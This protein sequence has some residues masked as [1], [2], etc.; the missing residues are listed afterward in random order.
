LL[1]S[2][3]LRCIADVPTGVF[4]SSGIDS[5]TITALLQA[6]TS[7][8]VR[9]F[10]IGFSEQAYDE[11]ND[12]S[13][14]AR[15]LGTDHLAITVTP[16]DAQAMIPKIP[17]IF[18]EPFSDSSL[19]PTFLLA[20]LARAT[21]KVALTGDGGD[22]IFGGYNRHV[23]SERIWQRVRWMPRP[24]RWIFA[25]SMRSIPTTKWDAVARA[26]SRALPHRL[27]HRTPGY[28]VHKLARLLEAPDL[29]SG[30]LG[31]SSHWSEPSAVM[32]RPAEPRSAAN[33]ILDLSEFSTFTEQMMLWDT[34]TYLPDN[35]LVKVDRATM[36]V[37]LEA[38]VPL[39]DPRVVEFA[40][41]L[42]I[43]FKIRAGEGKWFLRQVLDRHVPRQ[44]V[45]RAK[46]GFAI[47]LDAWL[48]GPL[49]DWAESMLNPCRIEE[50]GF[51]RA[52]PIRRLWNDLLAGRGAW[53]YH[54]WDILMFESWLENTQRSGTNA[55][56]S[57][58]AALSTPVL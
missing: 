2:V 33:D 53:Q 56:I 40:W 19:I 37:G 50:D 24:L 43:K 51:F 29:R 6:Q 8:R 47:P 11:L 23:W 55:A 17:E 21:V 10:S 27:R 45:D 30:Y 38:R 48:R 25:R 14:I 35:I 13:R 42:P 52:A 58:G 5:S 28:K 46:S 4:L 49:R 57:S 1:D 9:T 31:L 39:L 41:R 15:H 44:L 32:C 54:L 16:A 26:I 36:A 20:R 12:A 7:Q 3:R 22:E 18:S 34:L